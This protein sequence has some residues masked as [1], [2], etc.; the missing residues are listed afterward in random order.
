M[1][2]ST[3]PKALFDSVVYC[4]WGWVASK[5]VPDR[6]KGQGSPTGASLP[7]AAVRGEGKGPVREDK[8]WGPAFLHR[9]SGGLGQVS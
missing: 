6:D 4:W 7:R 3:F 1:L 2:P 9:T 8:Q 5:I